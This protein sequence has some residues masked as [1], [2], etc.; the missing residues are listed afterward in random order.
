MPL[1]RLADFQEA[2]QTARRG[3]AYLEADASANRGIFS[4]LWDTPSPQPALAINPPMRRC[5]KR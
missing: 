4:L 1:S 5:G 2:T 3:L